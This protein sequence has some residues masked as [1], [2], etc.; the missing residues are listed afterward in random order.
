MHGAWRMAH[1]Y[2]RVGCHFCSY[3]RQNAD[4]TTST[5]IETR[6]GRVAR[7]KRTVLLLISQT[8]HGCVMN[9]PPTPMPAPL[10]VASSCG[11]FFLPAP[12]PAP[13]PAMTLA[14]GMMVTSSRVKGSPNTLR[15]LE[16][17]QSFET[18]SS[19]MLVK[20]SVVVCTSW[21]DVE[22]GFD[23]DMLQS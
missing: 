15:T 21:L 16:L 2:R 20:W 13:K 12:A 10:P 18:M 19:T 6:L 1:G 7:R 22:D 17:L 11:S 5:S 9:P 23:C 8:P 4:V 3:R 14:T